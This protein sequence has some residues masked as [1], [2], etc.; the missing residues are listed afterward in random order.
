[1]AKSGR[2]IASLTPLLETEFKTLLERAMGGS[3]LPKLVY[4]SAQCWGSAFKTQLLEERSLLDVES[5]I[6]ACGDFCVESS[7]E[8]ALLSALDSAHQIVKAIS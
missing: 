4:S 5:R 8:G 2:D 7:A 1:M 3:V 6:A